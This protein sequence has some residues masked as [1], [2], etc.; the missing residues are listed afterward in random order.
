M[1]I[2]TEKLRKKFGN[3]TALNNLDMA[4]E[5]GEIFGLLGP[6]G[7]GKTTLIKILCGLLKPTSGTAYVAGFDIRESVKDIK[8]LIGVVPQEKL[9]EDL[10]TSYEY[11][12]LFGRLQG[13]RG[14]RLKN[15]IEEVLTIVGLKEE[16]HRL[17]KNLS[18]GMKKR[19][20]IG[21]G[22]IH[23]PKILFLDEPTSG[24]DPRGRRE[25]W[26]YLK[27]INSEGTTIL[28]ATHD[29]EEADVLCDRVGIINKGHLVTVGRPKELKLAVKATYSIKLEF[30][31]NMSI[32]LNKFSS[33]KEAR[34]KEEYCYI[35]VDDLLAFFRE[36][37]DTGNFRKIKTIQVRE[38]TLEDVFFK[39]TGDSLNESFK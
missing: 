34:I 33:I 24:L 31:E 39:F 22:I 7:A 25:I 1:I 13:L 23:K 30:K 35:L 14:S 2:K 18:G 3:V 15:R 9:C 27:K 20:A 12:W 16:A 28:L 26:H 10:I 38:P 19:L 17:A 29:M 11:L 21:I 8:P 5:E 4:V 32:E 36:L 6:N 37:M